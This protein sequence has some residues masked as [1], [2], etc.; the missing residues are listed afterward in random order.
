MWG[1]GS[2]NVWF[3]HG[4]KCDILQ[5][6]V[7]KDMKGFLLWQLPCHFE[8]YKHTTQAT[9]AMRDYGGVKSFFC[10]VN[11]WYLRC[12]GGGIRNFKSLQ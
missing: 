11:A 10:L 3:L 7:L 12:Y 5:I 8:C 9:K 2:V 4:Q 1:F 6:F